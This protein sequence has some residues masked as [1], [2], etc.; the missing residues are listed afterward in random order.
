MT[1]T[2]TTLHR[3]IATAAAAA[4][5]V[6]AAPASAGVY[7]PAVNPPGTV[8]A[9]HAALVTARHAQDLRSPDVRDV[10]AVSFTQSTPSRDLR[11][12]DARDGRR[13]VPALPASS[14]P[15]SVSADDGF[16]WSDAGI[17]AAIV[18]LL[19][20]L[21]VALIPRGRGGFRPAMHH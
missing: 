15:V 6:A 14:A 12:A 17:G 19:A 16:S 2:S 3:R 8:D 5:L 1:I 20:L 9:H 13:V 7:Q 11:S 4:A 18:A 10:T 21:G